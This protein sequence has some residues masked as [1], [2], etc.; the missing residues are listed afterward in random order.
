MYD[1]TDKESYENVK[2]WHDLVKSHGLVFKIIGNKI[3]KKEPRPYSKVSA[4]TQAIKLNCGYG[5]TS[6]LKKT[7]V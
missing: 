1:V 3:D 2:V 7:N 5:E 4:V 6:A